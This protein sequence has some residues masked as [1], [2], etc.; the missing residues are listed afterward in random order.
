MLRIPAGRVAGEGG[1]IAVRG[2]FFL[3]DREIS[4]GLFQQF[5][6]DPTAVSSQ[7]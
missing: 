4:V 2:D 7:R 1:L 6:D 5:M 3:S